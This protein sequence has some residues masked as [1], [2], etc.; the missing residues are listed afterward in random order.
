MQLGGRLYLETGRCHAISTNEL[1]HQDVTAQLQ[2]SRAAD[3]GCVEAHEVAPL[4]LSPHL[5]HLPGVVLAV[6]GPE[7]GILCHIPAQHL[8]TTLSVQLCP[9]GLLYCAYAEAAED[10]TRKEKKS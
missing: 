3:G 2:R 7:P 6:A 8:S 10:D 9:A 5:D 1:H 4:L